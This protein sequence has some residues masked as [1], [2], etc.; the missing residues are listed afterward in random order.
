MSVSPNDVYAGKKEVVLKARAE[1]KARNA[2][3]AF[4]AAERERQRELEA[5]DRQ[6]IAEFW[7]AYRKAM[8]KIADD[9]R[10][11]NLNFGLL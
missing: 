9:N 2:D 1:K 8:Q 6:A 4:W 7:M 11:S 10:P 3:A 5:K